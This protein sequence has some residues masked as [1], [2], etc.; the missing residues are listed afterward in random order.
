[1]P[2]LL[3]NELFPDGIDAATQDAVRREIA[4]FLESERSPNVRSKEWIDPSLTDPNVHYAIHDED[5][6]F[7]K[8]SIGVAGG[9]YVLVPN[10]VSVIGGLV[11][12]LYRY[13]RKRVKI[14]AMQ[15]LILKTLRRYGATGATRAELDTALDL[16]PEA[17]G[18]VDPALKALENM[19]SADGRT[20]A[21]V[22]RDGNRI[23]AVDV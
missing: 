21:F 10:P 7:W 12:F 15:A 11:V 9:L 6:G 8:E 18:H 14:D 1:M 3:S 17:R 16:R 19:V 2:D 13:R 23:W 5:F 22:R 20:T 4:R